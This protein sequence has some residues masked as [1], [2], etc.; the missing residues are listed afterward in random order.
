MLALTKEMAI[1]RI[2]ITVLALVLGAAIAAFAISQASAHEPH[3]GLNF[4]VGIDGVR[5]CNT[6]YGDATCEVPRGATFSLE[7]HLDRL[8]DDLPTYGGFDIYLEYDGVRALEDGDTSVWPDCAYPASFYGRPGRFDP[9]SFIALACAT[10]IPPAGP[11]HYAGIIANNSFVCDA[12]GHITLAH[13]GAEGFT[14]LVESE[15]LAKHSEGPGVRETLSITCGGSFTPTP[16]PTATPSGVPA[17]PATGQHGAQSDERRL[18]LSIATLGFAA[19]AAAFATRR[20]VTH[21]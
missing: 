7:V 14:D 15:T 10:G 3:P 17:L 18:L 8:P 5:G 1:V 6:R 2:P 9:P 16:T 13:G 19:L 11:S 12:P 4:V 20:H 21:G